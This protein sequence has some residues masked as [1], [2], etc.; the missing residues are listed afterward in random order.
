M[1]TDR[2]LVPWLGLA[3]AASSALADKRPLT[4]D[5]LHRLQDVS[6][7]AFAPRGDAV[8]YTVTKIGRAHV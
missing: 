3:L 8:I 7:P 6:E 2:R 4:I 5:D 1:R